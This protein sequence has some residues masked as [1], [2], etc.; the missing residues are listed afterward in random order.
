MALQLFQD[1]STAQFRALGMSGR[2]LEQKY[3]RPLCALHWLMAGGILTCFATVQLAK[4]VKRARKKRL[5]MMLHKSTALIVTALVLPRIALRITS[6]LPDPV[7]GPRLMQWGALLSH[8]ALYGFMISVP[9]SGLTIGYFGKGLPF[10][11]LFTI[12]GKRAMSEEDKATAVR[13]RN[14]HK[15]AGRIFEYMTILH[16]RVPFL[17]KSLK[18]EDIMPRITPS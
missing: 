11:N 4:M 6:T 17:Y 2:A 7:P 12:Q 13:A 16:W 14:F 18:G 1:Q 9:L 8:L 15:K 5:L 10:F 3:A